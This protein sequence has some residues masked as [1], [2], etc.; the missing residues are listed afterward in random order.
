MTVTEE[1]HDHGLSD[2]MRYLMATGAA[3]E[4]K[5]APRGRPAFAWAVRIPGCF[6]LMTDADVIEFASNERDMRA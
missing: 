2:A 3:S 1:G 6:Q 4:I 5:R